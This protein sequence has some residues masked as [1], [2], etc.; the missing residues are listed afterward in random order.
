MEDLLFL[1]IK[2]LA[3]ALIY[4]LIRDRDRQNNLFIIMI[5]EYY[6][7]IMRNFRHKPG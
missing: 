6:F 3:Y 1:I 4:V 2:L 5:Q 7:R